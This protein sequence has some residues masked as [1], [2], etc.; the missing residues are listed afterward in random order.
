MMSSP[1]DKLVHAF[2][3]L[4]GIG[5]KTAAR[6]VFFLLRSPKN[7]T[8]VLSESLKELHEKVRLCSGCCHVTDAD[9]CMYCRDSRRDSQM[10]CVVQE[11]SDVV[12]I[13]K[14]RHYKGLYHVLHGALSPL[15]GIGPDEIKIKE[16]LGRLQDSSCKEIILAVNATVE[17]ETTALYLS[18]LLGP[19]KMKVSRL[20]SGM[21]VGGELQYLDPSTLSKAIEERREMR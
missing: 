7:I 9:P 19:L 6:L 2:S 8:A 14:T 17:G 10:I 20:A 4:P 16:L 21:P 5:E 11:P 15:E 18:R 13:E 1:I 3:K 12:A